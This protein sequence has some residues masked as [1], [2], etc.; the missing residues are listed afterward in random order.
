MGLCL[1]HR[2][3]PS[4]LRLSVSPEDTDGPPELSLGDVEFVQTSCG[5]RGEVTVGL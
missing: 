3:T 5:T 2:N 4:P 1:L